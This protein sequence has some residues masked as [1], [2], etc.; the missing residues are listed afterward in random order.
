MNPADS[1]GIAA[2]N[3][4]RR[5]LVRPRVRARRWMMSGAQPLQSRV[6]SFIVRQ[7]RLKIK[8][9]DIESDAMLFG[10][11]L[12]LDSIDAL[13]LVVGIEK[14]FGVAITDQKIGEKVLKSV[15][16]IAMYLEEKGIS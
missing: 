2:G 9:E 16:S 3:G 8:P 5:T 14:E 6:K 11:K 13:E 12:G 7:L 4:N 10:G 1:P 15:S